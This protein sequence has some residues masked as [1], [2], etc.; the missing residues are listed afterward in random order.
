M[1]RPAFLALA[2]LAVAARA[3][4][5]Q[6][7]SDE[8]HVV[9][10]DGANVGYARTTVRR[11]EE[12]GQTRFETSVETKITLRRG[13]AVL[14]I[15]VREVTVE[16]EDGTPLRLR[17]ATSMSK[18]VTE[19]E[20]RF[21]PGRAHLTSVILGERRTVPKE[22]PPALVGPHRLARKVLEAGFEPGTQ[23]EGHV[24]FAQAMEAMRFRSRVVGPEAITLLDG[25]KRTLVRVEQ[26]ME[27]LPIVTT[28]WMAPDGTV[29]RTH[30]PVAG[31]VMESLRATRA[32]ALAAAGKGPRADVMTAS[33]LNNPTPVPGAR[34]VEAALLRLVPRE[35]GSIPDLADPRQTIEERREDG[36]VLV[37]VRRL[38][39]PPERTGRRP[40]GEAPE[41]VGASL[42]ASPLVQSDAPEIR[43]LAEKAVGGC[44]DAWEAARRIERFVK[45]YL[46]EKSLDVGFASAL[47]A[48]RDRSGDCTE[49]AVLFC[50]LARAAGIPARVVMGIECIGRIWGGHAWSEVWI[51][52]EWYALDPTIGNGA[53]DALH[54]A[55]ARS[56]LA[57]TGFGTEF[58]GVI[59]GLG[60]FDVE[61]LEA[62]LHGRTFR[63]GMEGATGLR[64]GRY[65]NRDF[66]ISFSV[67]PGFTVRDPEPGPGGL[68]DLVWL[69]G[70]GGA[71]IV[72]NARDAPEPLRFSN[73]LEET[74]IGD[75]RGW[76]R[77]REGDLGAIVLV[78]PTLFGIDARGGVDPALFRELVAS[79]RFDAAD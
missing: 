43:A 18:H 29:E 57:D 31:F 8:W 54:L 72:V 44:E 66:G 61:I 2:L 40:L 38:V 47:E 63:P 67:P 46:T 11:L 13:D 62:T 53:A 24:F 52:G 41:G 35:G 59:A 27:G 26:T 68:F 45:R 76:W 73:E 28:V 30:A 64:D 9:R 7:L 50:A 16:A 79:I 51:E 65:E 42:R 48:A 74:R 69:A 6:V 36:S 78:G 10:I 15:E 77:A 49:H 56:A 55:L 5:P 21:E 37:R 75:R 60:A 12:E 3:A 25:S 33:F 70:E 32:E 1:R 19:S 4:E 20:V 39:P 71:R 22:V 17:T 14:P 23:V 34:R 58:A